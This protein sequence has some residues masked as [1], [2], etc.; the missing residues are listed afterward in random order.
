M[1]RGE[2]YLRERLENVFDLATDMC[3]SFYVDD[4]DP[5]RAEIARVKK[6]VFAILR[7]KPIDKEIE[8]FLVEDAKARLRG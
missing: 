6:T 7:G 4:I 5:A 2:K 1:K 8:L 3:G